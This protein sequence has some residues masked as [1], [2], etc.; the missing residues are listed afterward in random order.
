M[1]AVL[2]LDSDQSSDYNGLQVTFNMRQ[3]NHLS[4][5]G[6]YTFSKTMSSAQLMNNTTQGLAQNYSRLGGRVQAGPTPTSAT[7]SA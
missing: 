3:W 2:L 6:F 5:N 4:F 7:C 1:G